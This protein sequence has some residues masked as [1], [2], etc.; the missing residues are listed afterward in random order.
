MKL[1]C[2]LICIACRVKLNK[3]EHVQYSL[4]T[5]SEDL[6]LIDNIK[7][8]A[9]AMKEVLLLIAWARVQQAWTRITRLRNKL[10]NDLVYAD[11]SGISVLKPTLNMKIS[12]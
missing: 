12:C 2:Y 3:N 4:L 10:Y 11:I 9:D 1:R 5:G 6:H 8:N 7:Q